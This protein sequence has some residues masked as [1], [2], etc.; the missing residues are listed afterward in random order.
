MVFVWGVTPQQK[1]KKEKLSSNPN[2]TQGSTTNKTPTFFLKFD[3]NKDG[4][5]DKEE[6][7]KVFDSVDLNHDGKLTMEEWKYTPPS[8]GN[9]KDTPQRIKKVEN[10]KE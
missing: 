1:P 6:M 3:S 8:K 10:L 2:P 7:V 5:V 9:V 4:V